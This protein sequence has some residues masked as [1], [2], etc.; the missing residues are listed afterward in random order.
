MERRLDEVV[1]WH[2]GLHIEDCP[3][4]QCRHRVA[5]LVQSGKETLVLRI[6]L[7]PYRVGGFADA[8]LL[9]QLRCHGSEHVVIFVQSLKTLAGELAFH[10]QCDH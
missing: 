7:F 8:I 9:D 3:N 2:W 10:R 5:G 6:E 4:I 1:G